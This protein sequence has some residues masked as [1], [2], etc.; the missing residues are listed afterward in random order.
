MVEAVNGSRIIGFGDNEG[1]PLTPATLVLWYPRIAGRRVLVGLDFS[2]ASSFDTI[3]VSAADVLE[4]HCALGPGFLQRF[5]LN[6][7]NPPFIV[8]AAKPAPPGKYVLLMEGTVPRAPPNGT[9][10]LLLRLGR[11][12]VDAAPD[13]PGLVPNSELVA[14]SPTVAWTSSAALRPSLV[15]L[16]VTLETPATGLRSILV[17]APGGVTMDSAR[18]HEV[19]ALNDRT[20]R[21][22]GVWYDLSRLTQIYFFLSGADIPPGEYAFRFP[23][24]LPPGSAPRNVWIFTLCRVERCLPT[25]SELVVPV[26]GLTVGWSATTVVTDQSTESAA[27]LAA[28]ALALALLA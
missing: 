12:V 18:R 28:F 22:D 19:A 1:F 6:C 5:L 2:S 3:E 4:L 7:T 11:M 16:G 26:P 20:P 9:V 10:T 21:K 27:S 23:V 13:V 17:L 24:F 14:H 8:M 25:K 15:T